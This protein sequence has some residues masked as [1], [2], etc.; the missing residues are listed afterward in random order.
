M[1]LGILGGIAAGALK[2]GAKIVGNIKERKEAKIEKKA[3]ALVEAEKKA[4]ASNEKFA[5]LLGNI[6][7]GAGQATAAQGNGEIMAFAGNALAALKGTSIAPKQGATAARTQVVSAAE[8]P[9][10]SPIL[11]IGLFVVALIILMKRR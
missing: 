10:M 2:I 8:P 6:G 1:A 3:A 11:L 9:K 5:T 7:A 4:A